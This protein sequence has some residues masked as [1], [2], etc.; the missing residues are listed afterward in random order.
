MAVCETLF[1]RYQGVPTMV[2]ADTPSKKMEENVKR[3]EKEN[4]Q[5]REAKKETTTHRAQMEKELKCLTKESLEHDKALQREMEKAVHDYPNS[6]EG[7][8]FLRAY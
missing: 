8:D 1:S 2:S 6:E 3:L 4:A 5:L 7:K